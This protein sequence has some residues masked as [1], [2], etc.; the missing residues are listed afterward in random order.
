MAFGLVVM[1]SYSL[2]IMQITTNYHRLPHITLVFWTMFSEGNFV[3]TSSQLLIIGRSAYIRFRGRYVILQSPALPTCVSDLN[4]LV[5]FQ[6]YSASR[7]FGYR[8]IVDLCKHSR[9]MG[10]MCESKHR[11]MSVLRLDNLYSR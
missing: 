9:G 2:P 10:D 4:A 6:N 3:A 7:G 8:S 11:S 1:R 5:C